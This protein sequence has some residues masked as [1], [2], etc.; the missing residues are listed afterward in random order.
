VIES[1]LQKAEECKQIADSLPSNPPPSV[2]AASSQQSR[3]PAEEKKAIRPASNYNSSGSAPA[4]AQKLV[5][6]VL[7]TPQ[8]RASAINPYEQMIE[9]EIIERSPA[10]DWT[11]I[12]GLSTAK[13]ILQEA[14]IKPILYPNIYTGLRAPPKGILL[15]GPPGTGKTLL[16]KAVASQCNATFLNVSAATLTSKNFGDSEKLVRAMFAVAQ[17]HQPAVIFMDEVD[18]MLG[19]RGE[20]QHEASRRLET[21]FLVQMDGVGSNSED[22]VLL[23]AATNRPQELDEAVRR[24]LTKRIYIPLPDEETRTT[25][26]TNALKEDSSLSSSDLKKIVKATDGYSGSDLAALCKEAAMDSVRGLTDKQLKSGKKFLITKK[27]FENAIKVIR[28]SVPKSS[29]E[30]YERW[31]QEFGVR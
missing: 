30:F 10:V 29:L 1:L 20:G 16:A 18:S 31:N 27:N 25:L 19:A 6:K 13:E 24:R 2:R 21:E 17:K 28:P 23:I 22:R 4:F 3:R 14:I 26:I 15:F 7:T 5:K 8:T 12:S 9:S 11:S